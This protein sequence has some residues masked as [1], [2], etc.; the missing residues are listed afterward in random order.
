MSAGGTG[1]TADGHLGVEAGL[2]LGNTHVPVVV[3]PQSCGL[4]TLLTGRRDH[5]RG[6]AVRIE[7]RNHDVTLSVAGTRVVRAVR[8][9][10][11]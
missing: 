2:G 8:V 9:D 10:H 5:D 7:V 3:A 4:I 11:R 6:A 1:L